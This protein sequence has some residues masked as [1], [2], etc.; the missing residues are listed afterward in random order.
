MR[1]VFMA[2]ILLR[3]DSQDILIGADGRIGKIAA[4]IEAPSAK[5]FELKGRLVV[6]GLVDAHQ[7]LD[8]TRTLCA[9]HNPRG[10]LGGTIDA[11]RRYAATMT[12]EDVAA[13]AERTLQA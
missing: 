2:Q 3:G 1:S 7:H 13:R 6:P 5:L 11:F 10:D 12:V 9:I 8:K 4:R